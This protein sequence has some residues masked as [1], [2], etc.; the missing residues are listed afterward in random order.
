[1]SQDT[2]QVNLDREPVDQKQFIP[3]FGPGGVPLLLLLF[4]LSFLALFTY[5]VVENQLPD[6]TKQGPGQI[7]APEAGQ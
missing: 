3:G 7:E 1:M 6:F 5:Y 4:Y 2:T